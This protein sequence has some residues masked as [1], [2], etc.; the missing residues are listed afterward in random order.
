M[1]SKDLIWA[2]VGGGHGGQAMA[3]HLAVQGNRVRIYDI[4]KEKVKVIN[5]QGGIYVDGEVEGFGPL[6]YAT[7]S[8]EEVLSGADIINVVTPG[9][10]SQDIGQ[11][12]CPLLKR[13]ADYR[14]SSGI[15]L[16]LP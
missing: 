5:R 6:Q 10:C 14:S 4:F 15:H 9:Q 16:R 11:T 12:V 13:R 8:I 1:S 7:T 3:A 2:V